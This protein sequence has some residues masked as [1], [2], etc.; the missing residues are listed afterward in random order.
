[1]IPADTEFRSSHKMYDVAGMWHYFMDLPSAWD[2]E[3]GLGINATYWDVEL[4]TLEGPFVGADVNDFTIA[5]F[6]LGELGYE[7][8]PHLNAFGY[9]FGGAGPNSWALNPG[10][11]MS[12]SIHENWNVG[13]GY[14]YFARQIDSDDLRAEGQ[15]DIVNFSVS[16]LF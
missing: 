16:H 7:I 12:Y 2:V 10:I 15:W 9:L 14:E 5:P 6:V 1:M 11:R 8:T 13:I 4:G 3:V